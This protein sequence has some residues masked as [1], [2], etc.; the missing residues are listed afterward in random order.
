[1]PKEK[2]DHVDIPVYAANTNPKLRTTTHTMT[3]FIN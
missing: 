2:K 3:I 1:M